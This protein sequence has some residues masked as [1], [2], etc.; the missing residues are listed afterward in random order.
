MEDLPKKFGNTYPLKPRFALL[1]AMCV[2]GIEGIDSY[3]KAL[4]SV[5]VSYPNTE[6]DKKA[7]EMV[8]LLSNTKSN[9]KS[10]TPQVVKNE[11]D[12]NKPKYPFDTE[13]NT[14]HYVLVVFE[15]TKANV[16]DFKNKITDF[17]TKNFNL[18]RLNVSTLM[19]D[20]SLPTLIVR[21][22]KD[23]KDAED[24]LKVA[25]DNNDFLPTNSAAFK[26]Y[27]IGQNNYRE[28]L[29][30]QNFTEYVKFYEDTFK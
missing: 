11:N 23:R 10:S 12:A 4:K 9:D 24:Y 1:A 18:L 19:L 25:V 20:G 6:E 14:G 21:K 30:K 28:V 15:D 5:S 2:G 26:L 16:N 27:F 22:F 13:I 3:I 8:A 7:K 17:N 29:Q